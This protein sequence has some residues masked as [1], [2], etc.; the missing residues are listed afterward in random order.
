MGSTP[1]GNAGP[2]TLTGT[3]LPQDMKMDRAGLR[4]VRVMVAPGWP[5]RSPACRASG[6]GG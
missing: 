3:A 5:S 4:R 6:C 1:D 2:A